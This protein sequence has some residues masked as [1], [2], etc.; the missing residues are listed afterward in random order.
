[1]GSARG[2]M[3]VNLNI[4]Q[5]IFHI[6]NF[7]KKPQADILNILKELSLFLL[8]LLNKKMSKRKNPLH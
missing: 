1:M 5:I 3:Q 7:E 6:I 2:E 4:S 8:Y